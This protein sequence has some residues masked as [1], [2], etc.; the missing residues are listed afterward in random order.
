MDED[1]VPA[2]VADESEATNLEKQVIACTAAEFDLLAYLVV[3][4]HGKVRVAL[5]AGPKDQEF[6]ARDDRGLPIRGVR[7]G[8]VLPAISLDGVA[9][10]AAVSLT[11]GP[12]ALGLSPITG[13]SWCERTVALLRTHGPGSLAYMEALLIAADRR[14][15]ML[16]TVDPL[17][18]TEIAEATR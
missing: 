10:L 17:L 9:L 7:D 1:E 6:I 12:A 11:L 2:S 15:S 16:T 13:R 4:H 3:S 8:D 18:A 5:H 14:A